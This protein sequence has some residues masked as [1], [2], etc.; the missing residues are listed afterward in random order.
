MLCGG[1]TTANAGT[2]GR[3]VATA[4]RRALRS[5][6]VLATTP[7]ALI[8]H[9]GLKASQ[10]RPSPHQPCASEADHAGDIE[11]TPAGHKRDR[12]VAVSQEDGDN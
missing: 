3:P 1:R 8:A 9:A 2:K 11:H 5:V 7:T 12:R 10:L 6:G 4:A